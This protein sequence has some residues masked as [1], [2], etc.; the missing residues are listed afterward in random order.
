MADSLLYVARKFWN[1]NTF[2]VTG[3]CNIMLKLTEHLG[4]EVKGCKERCEY[5]LHT[6]SLVVLD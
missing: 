3:M 6:Y 5:I 4:A 2:F 1:T